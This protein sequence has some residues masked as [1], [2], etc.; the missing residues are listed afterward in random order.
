[1]ADETAKAQVAQPGGDTIFAKI[2]R[3]EISANLIYE[4]DQVCFIYKFKLIVWCSNRSR[5]RQ[6][7]KRL[8]VAVRIANIGS[9]LYIQRL[10]WNLNESLQLLCVGCLSQNK[11]KQKART[12]RLCN[13]MKTENETSYRIDIRNALQE[14]NTVFNTASF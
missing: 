14:F 6:R 13:N 9:A 3:K 2:I 11:A 8:A 5:L 10:C 1:M 12:L 7:A 4:D